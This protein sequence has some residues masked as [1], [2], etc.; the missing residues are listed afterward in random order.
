MGPARTPGHD[1]RSL[2]NP[3]PTEHTLVMTTSDRP[4]VIPLPRTPLIGREREVTLL[5]EL[6]L[7]NDVPLVTLTGPGG[8]GKTRLALQVA[9]DLASEFEAGVAFVDLATIRDPI[10][11]LSTIAQALG[12]REVSER[13]TLSLLAEAIGSRRLL[14]LLDNF[15]HVAAAAPDVATLVQRCPHLSVVVTS[16]APLRLSV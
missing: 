11:V 2:V 6:V 3:P 8:V 13:D 10:L 14:L 4:H 5:R 15:E 7:R 12:V 9:A 1:R 16:R